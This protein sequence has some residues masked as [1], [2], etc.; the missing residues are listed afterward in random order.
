MKISTMLKREDFYKICKL[1]L[2]A[3]YLQKSNVPKRIYVYPELN[4]IVTAHPSKKVKEFIYTEY[5]IVS[6]IPRKFIVW[7]YTRFCMNSFG[8]MASPKIKFK[9]GIT[10]DILIYPC[11]RKIR[12]FDFQSGT[13]DIIIKDGFSEACLKREIEFRTKYTAPFI[14]PLIDKGEKK[15][16][17]KIIDGIPLA[18]AKQNYREICNKTIEMW[19]NFTAHTH[20]KTTISQYGAELMDYIIALDSYLERKKKLESKLLLEFTRTLYQKL[21]DSQ[22]TVTL[23]LS[24]GDLQPGNVWI[25]N[26]TDNIYIIDWETWGCRSIWYDRALLFNNLRG[27]NGIIEYYKLSKDEKHIIVV[28][29]DILFRLNELKD[30]PEDYGNK[31][32]NALLNKLSS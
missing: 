31:G 29:E 5:N 16:T 8:L 4:A 15:Y 30:L 13:V 9:Y 32:F 21:R 17:E 25:E 7:L 2:E 14:L 20:R 10:N 22:N 12:I 28:L 1:T 3:Y 23:S 19:E 6:S 11:N 24:H 27:E 26:K 18:R